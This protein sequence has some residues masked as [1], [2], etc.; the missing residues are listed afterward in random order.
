MNATAQGGTGM[1]YTPEA[2]SVRKSIYKYLADGHS[3]EDT[4][5]SIVRQYTRGIST[6]DELT[7]DILVLNEIVQ[8]QKFEA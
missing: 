1:Q 7:L 3:I 4:L 8:A 6:Q 2:E 5:N